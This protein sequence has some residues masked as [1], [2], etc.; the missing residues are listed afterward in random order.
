MNFVCVNL[1]MMVLERFFLFVILISFYQCT[2][3]PT[4][5][6]ED[7]DITFNEITDHDEYIFDGL[8]TACFNPNPNDLVLHDQEATVTFLSYEDD[9]LKFRLITASDVLES[10]TILT[11][12]SFCFEGDDAPNSPDDE[13]YIWIYN[14]IDTIGNFRRSLSRFAFY[15]DY[16]FFSDDCFPFGTDI[17]FQ[18]FLKE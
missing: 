17:H 4:T 14:E 15:F 6:P 9:S 8:L 10:D 16:G 13:L 5:P 11:Y 7:C 2:P 3:L 1:C 18:G 12:S